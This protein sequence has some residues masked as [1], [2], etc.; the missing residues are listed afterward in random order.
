MSPSNSTGE[1]YKG[2]LSLYNLY[3]KKE[4]IGEEEQ[5]KM[6]IGEILGFNSI[7]SWL[8]SHNLEIKFLS[9]KLFDDENTKVDI[10]K[11]FTQSSN[12]WSQNVADIDKQAFCNAIANRIYKI[13][14]F[15]VHT[16]K[17]ERDVVFTPDLKSFESLNEDLKFIRLLSFR[18]LLARS[19]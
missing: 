7:K 2:L 12:A 13:R 15:I 10:S 16:K 8:I 11:V 1:Y 3:G 17:G 4:K 9:K 6:V 5:I 14:N 19:R 18:V